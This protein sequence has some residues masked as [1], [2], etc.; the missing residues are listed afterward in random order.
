MW[1]PQLE[2]LKGSA[3]VIAV[4]LKGFGESDAPSDITSCTMEAYADEVKQV[5][6]QLRLHRVIL[7]GLALGGWVALTLYRRHPEVVTAMVLA[8]TRPDAESSDGQVRRLEQQRLA[9]KSG[10]RAVAGSWHEL[11]TSESSRRAQPELAAALLDLMDDRIEGFVGALEAVKNRPD[12]TNALRDI[13]VPTLI[14]VGE[15][16]QI[17]PPAL[18]RQMHEL[19]AGSKLSILPGV[20]T[21]T[22]LEA[23]SVFNRL[24]TQFTSAQTV[25]LLPN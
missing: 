11:L 21:M 19:I 16:D 20:G 1:A 5:I 4:D 14:I 23:P 13:S 25:G 6:D 15:S 2:G 17:S 7:V 22:N 9:A 12:M 10:V 18:S 24:V 8:D 3:R